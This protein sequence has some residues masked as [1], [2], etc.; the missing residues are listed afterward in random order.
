MT[1][2]EI[3]TLLRARGFR[4]THSLGQNFL[5]DEDVLEEIVTKAAVSGRNVLEIGAGA[6]CLTQALARQAGRVLAIEID[7]KLMPVLETVLGPYKNVRLVQGDALK[8][9]LAALTQEAFEGQPFDVLA[10]LPYYITT[11]A[12]FRLLEGDLPIERICVMLQKDGCPTR[13][14]TAKRVPIPRPTIRIMKFFCGRI[15]CR[16]CAILPS[17]SISCSPPKRCAL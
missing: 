5:I 8:L 16:Y 12:L 2:S 1:T 9:D 3:M 14:C 11:P 7:D 10:N 4:F 17:P 6:G 13:F 15:L